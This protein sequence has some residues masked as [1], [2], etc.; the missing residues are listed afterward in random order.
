MACV[1][2]IGFLGAVVIKQKCTRGGLHSLISQFG[3]HV[4]VLHAT[5]LQ[6]ILEFSREVNVKVGHYKT[7]IEEKIQ[8][9]MFW[10]PGIV[11]RFTSRPHA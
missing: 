9:G 10:S 1:A 6:S 5:S 7:K 3:H 11:H 8:C 2:L 4:H